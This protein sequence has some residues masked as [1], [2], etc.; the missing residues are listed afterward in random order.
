[1]TFDD[2]LTQLFRAPHGEFVNERKRLATELRTAG[3]K[4]G[5]AQ[6]NKFNRPP[7]S[8]W[9]VNQLWWS[10]RAEFEALLSVAR[11]V[12]DGELAALTEHKAAL[13]KL[14]KLAS[15]LL[16]AAGNA[17]AEA[18]LRRVEQSL[19]TI[20]V[21]GGFAPDR[22]GALTDDREPVGFASLGIPTMVPAV[23]APPAA[24]GT[25]DKQAAAEDAVRQ[26][27]EDAARALAEAAT[28]ARSE[29]EAHARA[30]TEAREAMRAR[31][32]AEE[33]ARML[34]ELEAA[35]AKLEDDRR[36]NE[37]AARARAEEARRTEE[38]ARAKREEE[39]RRAEAA[40]A[41]AQALE[42]TRRRAEA[43]LQARQQAE[44]ERAAATARARVELEAK[45][46][47]E[48]E[49][50][51]REDERRLARAEVDRLRGE[52][53]RLT[54]ELARMHTALVEAERRLSALD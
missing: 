10:S 50:L 9:A 34:R 16:V 17:A 24:L 11:R 47:A 15:E 27:A 5:A 39:A 48:R 23:A 28:R 36:R 38:T 25:Q 51:R 53:A 45:G 14:V 37:E 3:D 54:G 31:L 1:M 49:G 52:V 22:D 18:T 21:S 12:R 43:D 46:Q 33:Q 2:A 29:I 35:K 19:S 26:Q 6:L 8:A 42:D 13:A 20:A 32:E 40:K 41:E 44:A 7:I 4:S 30:E